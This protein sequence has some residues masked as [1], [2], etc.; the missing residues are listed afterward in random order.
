MEET[1]RESK[2]LIERIHRALCIP[3]ATETLV[4]F[5]DQMYAPVEWA[6]LKAERELFRTYH[7]LVVGTPGIAGWYKL[8][9]SGVKECMFTQHR[10]STCFIVV[11]GFLRTRSRRQ[12]K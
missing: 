9:L 6:S 7:V 5:Y 3:A 4:Y 12:G 10:G 11:F 8:T 1:S 2:N